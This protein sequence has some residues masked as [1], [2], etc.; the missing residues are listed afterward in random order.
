MQGL[1]RQLLRHC[2]GTLPTELFCHIFTP[3][4]Q[5]YMVVFCYHAT[6]PFF[7]F[8]IKE[9]CAQGVFEVQESDYDIKNM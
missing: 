4:S 5:I 7:T 8:K 1:N 3:Q 6:Q 2:R 9:K